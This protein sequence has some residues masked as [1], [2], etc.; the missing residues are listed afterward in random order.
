MFAAL[1]SFR[2]AAVVLALS[3]FCAAAAP[4]QA[5]SF[6]YLLLAA[7][8]QP[9][10]CK[11][12]TDK[13]EC[14]KLAG[15]H[16]ATNLILHGLWPNNY[17]G[18]HPFYCGVSQ[19]QIN[20]DNPNTWCQMANYGASSSTLGNLAYNM[21]GTQSCL[22]KHEWYKHGSCD[23][24]SADAY[25]NQAITLVSRLDSSSFNNYLRNN[26]GNKLSRSQLLSAFSSSF[27]SGTT[28]A[29]ALQCT[30]V[31]G[32][33]YLTEVWINLDLRYVNNFPAVNS[34]LTDGIVNGTCPNSGIMI[35]KP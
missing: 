28:A 3:T 27:G 14:A 18:N 16:A 24:Q 25:W 30:K 20:L 1:K 32:V 31:N 13:P 23:G 9:G 8:W 22:D 6:D 5:A 17:D 35:A 7:S 19:T 29:A 11:A 26:A 15:T 2:P 21:P 10:F 12:H 4:V 33:S 34:F